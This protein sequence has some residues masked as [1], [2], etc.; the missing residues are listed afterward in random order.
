MRSSGGESHARLAEAAVVL[1]HGLNAYGI[2]LALR[3][4]AWD[5]AVV[6]VREAGEES[7]W[8]G[9]LPGIETVEFRGENPAEILEVLRELR[10]RFA[11][12]SVFLTDERFHESLSPEACGELLGEM[13]CFVG[14]RAAVG[15]V[16]DR[17]AFYEFVRERNLW[18]VPLTVAGDR[19]PW[20]VLG[21]PFL[22]RLRQ[23]WEGLRRLERVR[24]IASEEEL[25]E[26]IREEEGA[27]R[28]PG[29]WCYQ[30]MLSTRPEDNVSVSGWHDERD[31]FY[32]VS[33]V[34]YRYPAL[35]GTALVC[36]LCGGHK[37][38]EQAARGILNALEYEGPFEMEFVRDLRSGSFKVI[39]LNPRFWL[40]HNL[41]QSAD[42]Y[43]I[44]EKYLGTRIS[45]PG[46]RT[47]SSWVNTAHA[48]RRLSF[49]DLR[50]AKYLSG[51]STLRM[52]A[53]DVALRAL[54]RELARR[55]RRREGGRL[56]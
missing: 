27:D 49:G 35:R 13:T 39:E 5:G 24:V 29:S 41:V 45:S 6:F 15:V 36:E 46:P 25:R 48:L 22:F 7:L 18:E 20:A 21:R 16:L 44:L 52:P 55:V 10:G 8:E 1:G 50:M 43:R 47:Y 40:Q 54:F 51:R 9:L 4:C 17:Y 32:L 3:E 33:R 26:V 53:L 14:P 38:L 34:V 31:Q 56:T 19:E 11:R 42:G 23:S 28:R 30:E 12:I 37:D 2:G